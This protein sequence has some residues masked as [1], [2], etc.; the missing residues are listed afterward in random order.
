MILQCEPHKNRELQNVGN[1]NSVSE[2]IISTFHGGEYHGHPR[3]LHFVF[4]FQYLAK[5]FPQIHNLLSERLDSTCHS[6]EVYERVGIL[7]LRVEISG[8]EYFK[9]SYLLN[10]KTSLHQN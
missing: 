2:L 8:E 1:H 3:P 7:H 6:L 4:A 9:G 10:T 5:P